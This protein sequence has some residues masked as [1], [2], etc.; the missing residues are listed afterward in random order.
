MSGGSPVD[1]LVVGAGPAGSAFAAEL[2]RRGFEPLVVDRACFPRAKP[3]GECVNAGALAAL[4]R[5]GFLD[6]VVH[7]RPATIRRW[8]VG[9]PGQRAVGRSPGGLGIERSVFDAALVETIRSR[10]VRVLE[11]WRVTTVSRRGGLWQVEAR[12]GNTHARWRAR[13]LVGA[14]G[15]RSVVSRRVGLLDPAALRTRR[16]KVSFTYRVRGT[17]PER[18]AGQLY[19]GSGVTVGLAPVHGDGFL[20]NAT[21][22]FDLSGAPAPGGPD[23]AVRS[24]HE[25]SR[26]PF[27]WNGAPWLVAGP[28]T[29]GP[30][31]FPVRWPVCHGVLLVGDAAGYFDPL[32]GQGIYRALRSA[33]L[34]AEA[35]AGALESRDLGVQA[36]N[37]Y[38]RRWHRETRAPRTFQRGVDVALRYGAARRGVFWALTKWPTL[39]DRVLGVTGD[40]LPVCALLRLGEA[41]PL[42]GSP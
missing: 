9:G 12:R 23:L 8:Y 25:V 13:L 33:E 11:G 32:T 16:R 24:R 4:K 26:A 42:P 15:L 39:A 35:A 36:L 20:W 3:C 29:S 28:W 22:V 7:T 6:A 37:G 30:F 31:V 38:A 17:G 27:G 2:A 18:D 1:A 40:Y 14:D 41:T 19:V 10:G 34:G 21:V 5:I